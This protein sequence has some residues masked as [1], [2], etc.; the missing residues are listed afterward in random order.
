LI[1]T[2]HIFYPYLKIWIFESRDFQQRV[3]LT[4]FCAICQQKYRRKPR[5]LL[6]MQGGVQIQKD[7]A[8][9]V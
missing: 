7:L 3:P 1:S 6:R 4:M 2:F 8:N 9:P 5:C